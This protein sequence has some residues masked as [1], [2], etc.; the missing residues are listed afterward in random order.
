MPQQ[1]SLLLHGKNPKNL[2]ICQFAALGDAQAAQLALVNEVIID[3][4]C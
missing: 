1:D 4:N 3:L 2:A